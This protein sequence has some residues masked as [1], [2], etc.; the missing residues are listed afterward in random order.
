[1]RQAPFPDEGSFVLVSTLLIVSVGDSNEW[2][3]VDIHGKSSAENHL[4]FM[5]DKKFKKR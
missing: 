4:C 3:S 1:M 5:F 2:T